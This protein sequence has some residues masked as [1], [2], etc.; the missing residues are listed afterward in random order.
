MP[1]WKTFAGIARNMCADAAMTFYN[2]DRVA[3][4]SAILDRLPSAKW[5]CHLRIEEWA[6]ASSPR[7]CW[8]ICKV[9]IEDC[10]IFARSWRSLAAFVAGTSSH[11]TKMNSVLLALSCR[12]PTSCRTCQF[13]PMSAAIYTSNT[14]RN[15]VHNQIA[16]SPQTF[17]L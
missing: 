8:I 7:T 14:S 5:Q 17:R 1:P 12:K 3:C 4:T 10:L 9:L 11:Y 2:Q 6:M 16:T 13:P 15:I